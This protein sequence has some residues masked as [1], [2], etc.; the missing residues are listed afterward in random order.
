MTPRGLLLS[1]GD[2]EEARGRAF[3]RVLGVR[4]DA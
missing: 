3:F 1:A 2:E 4:G